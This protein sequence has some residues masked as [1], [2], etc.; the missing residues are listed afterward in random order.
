VED[1]KGLRF[2]TAEVQVL[3]HG[4]W[5][6]SNRQSLVMLEQLEQEILM[7]TELVDHGERS[8]RHRPHG[9]HGRH[10]RGNAA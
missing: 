5:A 8:N 7:A 3:I 6:G 10:R 1:G 4:G 9:L 2:E